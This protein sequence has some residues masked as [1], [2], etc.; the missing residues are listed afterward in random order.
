MT[1]RFYVG[2]RFHGRWPIF[3]TDNRKPGG[4][5]RK[6]SVHDTK[7][8]ALREAD[9]LNTGATDR[10]MTRTE[11]ADHALI[12][13]RHYLAGETGYHSPREIN[14]VELLKLTSMIELAMCR[15]AGVPW[16]PLTPVKKRGD[17]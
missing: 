1:A 5:A 6:V 11:I 10:P 9:R 8:E 15:G 16:G 12:V 7:P 3:D 2:A 13:A 14:G 4:T 17:I